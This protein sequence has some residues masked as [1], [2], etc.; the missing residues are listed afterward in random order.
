MSGVKPIL[1]L[2]S[3][4]LIE[5]TELSAAAVAASLLAKTALPIPA[6]ALC[7]TAPGR[8]AMKL[9]RSREVIRV[10]GLSRMTIWRMERLGLFPARRRLGANSVAWLEGDIQA[11]IRS[12]PA[13]PPRRL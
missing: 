9:L 6:E 11:W 3:I 12:R 2:Q 8:E 4:R 13:V 1:P 10:T 5:C 7:N